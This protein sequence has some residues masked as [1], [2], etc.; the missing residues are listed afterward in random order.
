MY[1]Y[2]MELASRL[3]KHH[4][5][6]AFVT[7]NTWLTLKA[8]AR[9]RR[10]LLE[11]VSFVE[12]LDTLGVFEDAW[13]NT[14][15]V[16]CSSPRE[17]CS[18]T[19]VKIPNKGSSTVEQLQLIADDSWRTSYQINQNVWMDG[20]DHTINY[21]TDLVSRSLIEKVFGRF[22]PV[23]TLFDVT[24]GYQVYHNT[25]HS[26]K[27]IAERVFHTTTPGKNSKFKRCFGGTD[28]KRY[29]WACSSSEYVLL[30]DNLYRSPSAAFFERPKVLVQEIFGRGEY[31]VSAA[32]AQEPIYYD[33][34]CL[35]I[36]TKNAGA[37]QI[38]QLKGLLACLNS[39]YATW[40]LLVSGNKPYG[41]G[42]FA[43]LTKKDLAELP[44]P[45][46]VL[47]STNDL[48]VPD[49]LENALAH[50]NLADAEKSIEPHIG[51]PPF[52]ACLL[53]CLVRLVDSIIS[54][55]FARGDITRTER[56]AL[57]PEA[58]P[59]QDLIDRILFRMAGLSDA[60]AQGLEKRLEGML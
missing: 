4:G 12:I 9:L 2:F 43:R 57:A 25:I 33:K 8:F 49:G 41:T 16:V 58:Q 7:P 44:T 59:Y 60:E 19:V 3:V 48:R 32:F 54:I 34:S 18:E 52:S 51:R 35:G 50:F 29:V 24:T 46:F 45:I 31:K 28:V 10:C 56:S 23:S 36:I 20:P 26:K 11:R 40:Y 27:Q 1:A 5:R 47:D 39:K 22:Q 30:G 55:E 14:A 42:D 6:F 17:P 15:V 38:P 13:V 53:A 21:N 37:L